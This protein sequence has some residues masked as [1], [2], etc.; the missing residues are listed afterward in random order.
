[1]Y[2]IEDLQTSYFPRFGGSRI[3]LRKKTTSI[4]FLKSLVDSINYEHYDRPFFKNKKF[5]GQVEFIHFYQNIAVLKKG[6]SKKIFY[7][8][9]KEKKNFIE[10]IKKI[11]SFFYG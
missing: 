11:I 1:M 4:N 8:S 5:D 6:K 2:A 10:I 7:K 9:Q 3:N